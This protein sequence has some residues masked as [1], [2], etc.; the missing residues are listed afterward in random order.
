[1]SRRGHP[2]AVRQ[3]ALSRLEMGESAYAIARVMGIPQTTIQMWRKLHRTVSE[4]VATVSKEDVITAGTR[5]AA[6]QELATA[7]LTGNLK[8]YEE[9]GLRLEPHELK[10]VAIVAGISSDKFLDHTQGRKGTTINVPIDNRTQV[11]IADG[12][13]VQGERAV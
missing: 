13:L 4:A 2:E 7:V 1:M 11:L 12:R 10:D 5:W 3:E 8:H 9:S 6:V